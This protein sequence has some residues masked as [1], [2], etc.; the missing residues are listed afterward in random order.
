M[1]NVVVFVITDSQT[2]LQL[3]YVST[4]M[5]YIRAKFHTSSFNITGYRHE[6]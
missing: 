1:R 6:T 2:K 4:I 3:L 5:L